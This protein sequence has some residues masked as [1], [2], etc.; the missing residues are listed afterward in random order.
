M[1]Q[2]TRT[3]IYHF[4][5]V[6]LYCIHQVIPGDQTVFDVTSA[7]RKCKTVT[8]RD[9]EI[10]DEH[11]QHRISPSRRACSSYQWHIANYGKSCSK[12]NIRMQPNSMKRLASSCNQKAQYKHLINYKSLKKATTRAKPNKVQIG[13]EVRKERMM[14]RG[15]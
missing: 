13:K 11:F 6:A 14:T 12:K 7:S 10:L 15:I 9:V 4:L 5:V 2:V 3:R 1:F 8:T